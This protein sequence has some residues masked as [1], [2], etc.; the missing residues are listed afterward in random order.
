MGPVA[1]QVRLGMPRAF[2][3]AGDHEGTGDHGRV[4]G[5]HRDAHGL[6]MGEEA[7]GNRFGVTDNTHE[8]LG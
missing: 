1:L 4:G 8:D 7:V 2:V 3:T 6:Q 5:G